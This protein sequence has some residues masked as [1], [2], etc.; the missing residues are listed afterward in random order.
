[1]GSIFTWSQAIL[2]KVTSFPDLVQEKERIALF[3]V[4]KETNL[5]LKK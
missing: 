1:M 3:Q 4:K 2:F 5:K